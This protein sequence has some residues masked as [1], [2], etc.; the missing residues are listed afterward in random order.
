MWS[1]LLIRLFGMWALVEIEQIGEAYA[2]YRECQTSGSVNDN[3]ISE[4]CKVT[5]ECEGGG[6]M[7]V[8]GSSLGKFVDH[9]RQNLVVANADMAPRYA[10]LKALLKGMENPLVAP[11][12]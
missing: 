6:R 7:A 10:A 11:K 8:D 3:S 4:A 2:G 12:C 5:F 9:I 1:M